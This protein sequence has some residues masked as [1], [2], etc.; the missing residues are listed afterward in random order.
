[1]A[2]VKITFDLFRRDILL[3]YFFAALG[4]RSS[5]RELISNGRPLFILVALASLF[6]VVQNVAGITIA[7]AFDFDP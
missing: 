6:I 1:M 7:R 2:D 5:L 3:V 4:L